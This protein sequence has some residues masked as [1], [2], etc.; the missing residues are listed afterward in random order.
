MY[1]EDFTT[2]FALKLMRKDLG[3][4]LDLAEDL[5]VPMS[6]LTLDRY[7]QASAYDEEDSS[8]VAKL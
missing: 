1:E 3:L 7:R 8:A 6:R 4:A 5:D 2:K